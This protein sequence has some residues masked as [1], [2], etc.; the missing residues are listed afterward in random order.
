MKF[1]V[2]VKDLKRVMSVCKLAVGKERPNFQYIHCKINKGTL[3]AT[4]IDGFRMHT[5][6]IPCDLIEGS[7]DDLK[8]QLPI[9]AMPKKVTTC[10]IEIVEDDV[11]FDFITE[12]STVKVNRCEFID[13][14][15][16][17]IKDIKPEFEIHVNPKYL[18]DALKAF[19]SDKVVK[20]EFTSV[21]APIMIKSNG[22]FTM[23]MPVRVNE[24]TEI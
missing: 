22:D 4:T 11:T 14:D 7:N 18:A 8:F 5:V 16:F 6:T 13:S 19:N 10:V 21:V 2:D 1:Q 15:K 23:V 12:R 17:K 20:L 9:I 3:E 24:E